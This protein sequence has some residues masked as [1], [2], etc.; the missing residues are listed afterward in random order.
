LEPGD[1]ALELYESPIGKAISK[2]PVATIKK[3]LEDDGKTISDDLVK[4]GRGFPPFHP[5]CRTR[6]EGVIEGVNDESN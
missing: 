4:M 1:F 6:L 2:D 3:F 5:N